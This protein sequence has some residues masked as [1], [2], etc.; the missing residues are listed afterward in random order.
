MSPILLYPSISPLG[1]M[2]S[3]G[4]ETSTELRHHIRQTLG[5]GVLKCSAALSDIHRISQHG[6]CEDI[7]RAISVEDGLPRREEVQSLD[8]MR[9]LSVPEG[10]V[11]CRL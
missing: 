4:S 6:L 3:T 10:P 5:M 9:Y 8:R 7:F 2:P 11:Q 1:H